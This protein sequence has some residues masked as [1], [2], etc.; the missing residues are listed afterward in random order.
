MSR[1]LVF[2][3]GMVI[4]QILGGT[5]LGPAP[6][7]AALDLMRATP[8]NQYTM[9]IE[10]S[11][12]TPNPIDVLDQQQQLGPIP[13][14]PGLNKPEELVQ[15]NTEIVSMLDLG[16]PYDAA[17]A[18]VLTT[19]NQD[20]RCDTAP[21]Q[22]FSSTKAAIE[23]AFYGIGAIIIIS[24]LIPL[25]REFYLDFKAVNEQENR[26]YEQYQDE[27]IAIKREELRRNRS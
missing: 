27:L 14:C 9:T 7:R 10:E 22:G 4:S 17:R 5:E 2:A 18:E 3:G 23:V 26:L 13:D 15:F 16:M 8:Q 25:F 12:V 20:G 21:K 6:A 11:G 24:Y 19:L 1:E